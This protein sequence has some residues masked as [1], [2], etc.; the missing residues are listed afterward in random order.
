MKKLLALLLAACVITSAHAKETVTIVYAFSPA[1]TMANYSRSLVNEANKIQD[2]YTF[3]FDTKPGAGNAIAANYVKNTPNTI[4]ATSSAFFVRPNFYPNESYNINDFKELMPQ[5]DAPLGV[6]SVKYKSWNDVPT[7]KRLN[8]GVSGLGVTTHLTATQVV[9]KYPNLQVVPFKSTNESILSLVGGFTDIHIGFL[10]E[11]ETW[12]SS[13]SKTK[14]YILGTTG[15]KVVNKHTT[16]VSQ[17]FPAMLGRMNAP[18][19]LVIPN[20]VSTGKF[21]EWREILVKAA[22]AKSVTNSYAIDH[23]EPMSDMEDDRIQPWYN[24]QA[25]TWKKL[26]TGVKLD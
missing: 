9:S 19:H 1:D 18:H 7:D 26:S 20:T 22:K 12:G 11:S 13:T 14:V 17:G 25:A 4:L 24:A 15:N 2:K 10:G 5:C 8:I 23:C 6:A 3:I 21:I 16:L